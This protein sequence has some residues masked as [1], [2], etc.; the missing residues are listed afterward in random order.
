MANDIFKKDGFWE[1]RRYKLHIYGFMLLIAVVV[2]FVFGSGGTDRVNLLNQVTTGAVVDN[3]EEVEV[4]DYIPLAKGEE[5]KEEDVIFIINK[6]DKEKVIRSYTASGTYYIVTATVTS[7][8]PYVPEMRM[9]SGNNIIAPDTV[10]EKLYGTKVLLQVQGSVRGVRVFDIPDE[11]NELYLDLDAENVN[12]T[13][14]K[15]K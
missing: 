5:I 11:F 10:V 2:Y 9:I 13:L 8:K 1:K 7:E 12:S 6:I 3:T 4:L 14:Y 15:I